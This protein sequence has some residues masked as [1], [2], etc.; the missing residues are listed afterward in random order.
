MNEHLL[1]L[2]AF[3]QSQVRRL[4]WVFAVLFLFFCGAGY[5]LCVSTPELT[6]T[7]VAYFNQLVQESGLADESGS[8]SFIGLLINN[9]FATVFTV[10]YGFLPFLFLPLLSAASN[11]LILGA[12]AAYYHSADFPMAAFFAG[13]IPHGIF[14]IPALVLSVTL[15]FLLCRNLV[16]VIL[17]SEKAV[18]MVELLA[19]ILRAMLFLVFPLLLAAALVECYVTPSIMNLFL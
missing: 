9:W 12:V 8:I 15:G 1:E 19:N 13:I 5:A 14:E 16:R 10:L 17:R 4:P 3:G 2:R 11:A 18:P 7:I 6:E